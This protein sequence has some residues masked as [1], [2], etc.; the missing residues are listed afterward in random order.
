MSREL[1]QLGGILYRRFV[2]Y[3][4]SGWSVLT[5]ILITCALSSASLILSFI[6]DSSISGSKSSG[7]QDF[8]KSNITV[9]RIGSSTCPNCFPEIN[10]YLTETCKKELETDLK[11]VEFDSFD[12]FNFWAY[13]AQLPEK[14]NTN[15]VFAFSIENS[16]SITFVGD[17]AQGN[18][19]IKF[20]SNS[21]SDASYNIIRRMLWKYINK[22]KDAD[23]VVTSSVGTSSSGDLFAIIIGPFFIATGLMNV[24]SIFIGQ[25]ID[26][27]KSNRRPYMLSSGLKLL[28]F[29]LGSFI[30]DVVLIEICAIVI[31]AAHLL[32]KITYFRDYSSMTLYI[33]S[34]NAV[35]T[36]LLTYAFS[37][38][39]SNKNVGS[40]FYLLIGVVPLILFFMIDVIFPKADKQLVAWVG[41][42]IPAT[43]IYTSLKT[44]ATTSM[45]GD[46]TMKITD[47]WKNRYLKPLLI[48]SIA[49]TPLYAIIIFLIEIAS[50]SASKAMA[51]F[52]WQGNEE[53]FRSIKSQQPM[54]EEAL[55]ME[56]EV[57]NAA[58][59]D[60]AVWIKDV[61]K[62]FSDSEG[63]PLC[64][65]NQVSLGVKPGSLF[66]FLG[67]NGAGKT[68][69]LKMIL[70]E[71]PLS[72]GTIEIDGVNISLGFDSTRL[73]VC[74]QF[75]DHLTPELT[76]REHIRFFSKIY[77][78][79]EA[80]ANS[81]M[82]TLITTLG[83]EEH[84][85]KLVR[86]MSG[87][88]QRRV[89][90]ALAFLSD[91][92]IVL[93]D[94][95]TSS[96]DPIARHKVHNLINMYRGTKTFMLCT[97]LL[98][99]AETLCDNI[100]IML[101]GCVYAIGTP[102][103]LSNKFGT[104]WKVELVL[105]DSL[106]ATQMSIDNFFQTKLPSARLT[107]YRPL[108]RI[109]SI[110]AASIQ[111]TPLFR[112]LQDAKQANIG[113]KF[114]TCSCSTLEK[115]FLE[116]VMMSEQGKLKSEEDTNDDIKQEL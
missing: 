112:M 44:V 82:E 68:T 76:A 103:Y 58:P 98:D 55:Q 70:R 93:L 18:F 48:L 99:E 39:F 8:S 61:S 63:K 29:W 65:V 62:L 26:E 95:P 104:E 75:D 87:G 32:F 38:L 115:V 14:H 45:S 100:S 111:L 4:R 23:I 46:K 35:S 90:V 101:K 34:V 107:I 13:N 24:C 64:A 72:N 106:P 12:N 5:T 30:V 49:N 41:A 54:T 80:E 91:A 28:P 92:R 22:D 85:D 102:Q 60:Y 116:I 108:S 10:Q 2:V 51:V 77:G 69:L 83:I 3:K 57:A 53:L 73:A 67:A 16:S 9:A 33:L 59:G 43:N 1:D 20:M 6:L 78:L 36:V 105:S 66:G 21:S 19:D 81:R 11:I 37:F 110:P 15:V 42:V 74:P 109:Y 79:P 97:H 47:F 17:K 86:E 52:G 113:I 40:T 31:W 88:N 27:I 89:A 71:I 114:Y 50:Q 25:M 84:A 94:E 56:R 96:L 7:F